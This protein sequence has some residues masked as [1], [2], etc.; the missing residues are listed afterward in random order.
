MRRHRSGRPAGTKTHA[1]PRADARRTIHFIRRKPCRIRPAARLSPDLPHSPSRCPRWRRTA[2][3]SPQAAPAGCTT[4]WA[5]A[6]PTSCPSTS[7]AGR[8]GRGHR[9]L[10]RQPAAHRRRQVGGGLHDGRL[11]VGRLQRPRQ[12]QGQKVGPAHARRVLPEP[13]ARRHGRRQRHREARRPQGEARRHRG[14]RHR[15]R[16]DGDAAPRGLRHRRATRT[17]ARSAS[18]LAEIGERAQGRQG[19]RPH[20]GRRR[21]HA[22]A[23]PTSRPRRAQDQAHRPRRG[24]RG[25]A[26]EVRPALREGEDP[27]QLLPGPGQG[28]RR[29]STSGT[30]WSSPTR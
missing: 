2:S 13:D 10:D 23:S 9:R 6:W 15:H 7:P 12:V 25:D 30:S 16:G 22:G 18:S 1:S 29:T 26:Q 4:R 14:A 28:E 24:G 19:R 8:H 27:R 21:A 3:R 5:A 11:G 17:C 20:V